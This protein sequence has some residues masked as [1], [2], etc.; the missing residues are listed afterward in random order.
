[1]D[2]NYKDSENDEF[3]INVNGEFVAKIFNVIDYDEDDAPTL[4]FAN[5]EMPILI[6]N[7]DAMWFIT[8]IT[9]VPF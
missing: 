6:K 1:L 3:D 9:E 5:S 7:K 8:P 4:A 2:D